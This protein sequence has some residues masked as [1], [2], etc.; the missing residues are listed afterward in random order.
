MSSFS[1]LVPFLI[2]ALLAVAMVIPGL[3][4]VEKSI[5]GFIEDRKSPITQACY[6][7]VEREKGSRF[8]SEFERKESQEICEQR[9]FAQVKKDYNPALFYICKTKQLV[10]L[11]NENPNATSSAIA[12]SA[13]TP[14]FTDQC[15]KYDNSVSSAN[16]TT[17]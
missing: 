5:E 1:A 17:P 16:P 15:K 8:I 6:A 4:A 7:I 2:A 12:T 10:T 3:N 9:L 11:T 14:T 13:A